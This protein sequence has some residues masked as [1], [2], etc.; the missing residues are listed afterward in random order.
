MFWRPVAVALPST[1]SMLKG[2]TSQTWLRTSRKPLMPPVRNSRW[3]KT[4][5]MPG[6][7]PHVKSV[8]LLKSK[9]VRKPRLIRHVLLK[10]RR[11]LW[12]A[13]RLPMSLWMWLKPIWI[14]LNASWTW[15]SVM[16]SVVRPRHNWTLRK[17][18]RRM[19]LPHRRPV[20]TWLKSSP[21][22]KRNVPESTRS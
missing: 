2:R 17:P 12:I 1:K 3:Q 6:R 15:K 10:R 21:T 16:S 4:W 9:P 13:S 22:W 8:P 19:R 7:L 18:R 5:S 20:K 14:R 11:P